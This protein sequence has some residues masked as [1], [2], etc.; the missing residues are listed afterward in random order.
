VSYLGGHQYTVKTPMSTNGT[1]Q[2]TRLF[3]NSL[4]EAGCVT[5]DGQ[6][7]IRL[8]KMGP[9]TTTSPDVTWSIIYANGGDG[10]ALSA[11]LT[12]TLPAGAMFVSASN[13][14]TFAAGTVTWNLGDL[15]GPTSNTVTV[16]VRLSAFGTYNNHVEATYTV[17]LNRKTASSTTS[18]VEYMALPPDA[19]APDSAA[20]PDAAPVDAA[21][22]DAVGVDA[23]S[24]PD[25][26]AGTPADLGAGG[27][28]GMG[29]SDGPASVDAAGTGGASGT[30]APTAIDAAGTGGT[31]GTSVPD[32]RLA[33]DDAFTSS[34]P[35]AGAAMRDMGDN[36]GQPDAG[37][38]GNPGGSTTTADGATNNPQGAAEDARAGDA[39]SDDLIVG[40]AKGGGGCGC[41][42]GQRPSASATAS[43]VLLVPAL[44]VVRRRR[45]PAAAP[46]RP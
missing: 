14:G 22:V 38:G 33:S 19:S 39:G 43:W 20:D 25:A 8:F 46:V 17:G 37:A 27:S 9:A 5:A 41:R 44:L 7:D 29:G 42:I 31:G 30:D 12:D 45:R 11:V 2:G 40:H 24:S 23:V 36:G 4:Y 15:P 18:T 34:T 1:T 35:E 26:L 16:T 6:P 32:M 21:T 10:P 13:G 28:T 3:L